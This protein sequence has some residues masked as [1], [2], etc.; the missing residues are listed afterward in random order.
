MRIPV[1]T[2][3]SIGMNNSDYFRSETAVEFANELLNIQIETDE[4]Y[5][6]SNLDWKTQSSDI[7][8][9]FDFVLNQIGLDEIFEFDRKNFIAMTLILKLKSGIQVKRCLERLKELSQEVGDS[10]LN[11][12]Y[13]LYWA[14]LSWER[15]DDNKKCYLETYNPNVESEMISDLCRNW[16]KQ[17]S[18]KE[19]VLEYFK[20]NPCKVYNGIESLDTNFFSRLLRYEK[21]FKKD[22]TSNHELKAIH[23]CCN[24]INLLLQNKLLNR[25]TIQEAIQILNITLI[26]TKGYFSTSWKDYILHLRHLGYVYGME[27]KWNEELDFVQYT[28]SYA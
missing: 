23:K 7:K 3:E 9:N 25:K 2:Y 27:Y 16:L 12:F 8:E 22:A 11:D 10:N 13:L 28:K 6:L 20:M 14:K 4:I 26:K 24:S 1:T 17:F 18:I 15:N 5:E 19:R 21:S